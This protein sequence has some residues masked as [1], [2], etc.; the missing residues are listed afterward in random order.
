MNERAQLRRALRALPKTRRRSIARAIREGRAVGDPRD[1][2]LAVLW[3]RRVQDTF[4]P[5]W[6]FPRSRPRG[7]RAILWSAHLAWFL[8]VLA[9]GIASLWRSGG[10]LRWIVL[11]WVLYVVVLLPF[12]IV[13]V[14]RMRWNAPEAERRNRELLAREG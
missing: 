2:E 3:A 9:F 8:G 5:S 10:V 14:L 13:P 1:A 7:R 11:G 6:A 12:T 4:W